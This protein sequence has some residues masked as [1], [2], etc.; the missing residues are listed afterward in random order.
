MDYR[1]RHRP[2]LAMECIP[3]VSQILESEALCY[4]DPQIATQQEEK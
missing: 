1:A 2:H 4:V 3:H